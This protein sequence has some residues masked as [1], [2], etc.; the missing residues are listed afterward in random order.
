ME[1]GSDP[2][3]K[4]VVFTGQSQQ[5]EA[6]DAYIAAATR[7][8]GWRAVGVVRNTAE[9]WTCPRGHGLAGQAAFREG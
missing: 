4:T 5:N 1:E 2:I 3:E 8:G 9:E 6:A 7:S